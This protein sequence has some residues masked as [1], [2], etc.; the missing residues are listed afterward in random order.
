MRRGKMGL[1]SEDEEIRSTAQHPLEDER[2]SGGVVRGGG[3]E[4][5]GCRLLNPFSR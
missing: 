4:E 5:M 1:I 3:E 2:S